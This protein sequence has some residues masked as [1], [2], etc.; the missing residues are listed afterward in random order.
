[1]LHAGAAKTTPAVVR[2]WLKIE[3]NGESNVLQ[4]V[5]GCCIEPSHGGGQASS[6]DSISS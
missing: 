4:A 5:S 1:M 6:E 3:P 2:K